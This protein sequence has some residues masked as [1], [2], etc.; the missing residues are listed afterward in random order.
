MIVSGKA[1]LFMWPETT[2][3]RGSEEIA[4]ILLKYLSSIDTT[5]QKDLVIFTENCG[6]QNKNW[7]SKIFRTIEH[8]FL[9]SG[10]TYLPCDRDFALIEKH[11]KYLGQI[12]SPED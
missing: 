5:D 3:K 1:T 8:R 10:H 7:Q 2:A 4:S 11:K 12:Y 6:G 9:I